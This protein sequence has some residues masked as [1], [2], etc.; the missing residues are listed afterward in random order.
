M[1][2]VQMWDHTRLGGPMGTERTSLICTKVCKDMEAAEKWAYATVRERYP[3]WFKEDGTF[4]AAADCFTDGKLPNLS[5]FGPA[6]FT[7][8]EIEVYEEPE[9][10]PETIT[11]LTCPNCGQRNFRIYASSWFD[12]AAADDPT[13]WQCTPAVGHINIAKAASCT[14]LKC[15]WAGSAKDAK[16]AASDGPD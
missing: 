12:I 13:D 10:A 11:R 7:F 14:C 5:G 4:S 6:G 16:E 9:T 3:K 1:I 8:E 15:G 2:L